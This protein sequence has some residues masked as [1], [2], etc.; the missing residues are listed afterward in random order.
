MENEI[1]EAKK[2]VIE[3]FFDVLNDFLNETQSPIEELFALK[4]LKSQ[5]AF[6][7]QNRINRLPLEYFEKDK[8]F[9]EMEAT[10]DFYGRTLLLIPQFK[11]QQY[12][13]IDFLLYLPKYDIRIAIECDG[14]DFHEKTKEQ[15]K[16]D[17][18]R[19][20]Y[21]VANNFY[22]FRYSGSEIYEKGNSIFR[23]IE[24]FLI[25]LLRKR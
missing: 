17:K 18:Q 20:R 15:A 9:E 1:E 5:E 22:I 10:I 14:H 3:N 13:T 11:V 7:V 24:D 4:M 16:K 21:L 19:D 8:Q 12:H 23:E 2:G 25:N 6:Y